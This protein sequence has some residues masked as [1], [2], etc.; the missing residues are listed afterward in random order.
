[1]KAFSLGKSDD[2]KQF[3]VVRDALSDSNLKLLS[4]FMI[5]TCAI[6]RITCNTCTD[7][8][9]GMS[10]SFE[11]PL[12]VCTHVC[13]SILP[14]SFGKHL[15]FYIASS[16]ELIRDSMQSAWHFFPAISICLLLL[17]IDASA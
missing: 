8:S 5:I 10:I 12:T 11:F 13:M 7:E 6:Y 3:L 1:M 15:P 4:L 16:M 14:L 17:K 2:E 9:I